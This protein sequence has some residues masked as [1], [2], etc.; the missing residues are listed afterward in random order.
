MLYRTCGG[1]RATVA[2]DPRLSGWWQVPVLLGHPVSP[3]HWL[4]NFCGK[5]I[6]EPSGVAP[7][8]TWHFCQD[9]GAFCM[10]LAL[11]CPV[12]CWALDFTAG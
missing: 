11:N 3:K 12:G 1:Q 4:Y 10:G 7:L 6:I 9:A 2:V 8:S 5:R